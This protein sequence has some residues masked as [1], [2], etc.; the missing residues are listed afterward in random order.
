VGLALRQFIRDYAGVREDLTSDGAS[1]QTGPKTEFIKDV[2]KNGI[3]NHVSETKQHRQN[4]AESVIHKVKMRWFRQMNS[5]GFQS[6]CGITELCGCVKQCPS[7]L[8]HILRWKAE[9]LSSRP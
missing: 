6:D 5:V 7:R 3:E 8:A 2:Q 1:E 4:R 9:L